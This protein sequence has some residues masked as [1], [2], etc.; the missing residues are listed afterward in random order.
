MEVI[1][2]LENLTKNYNN[3]CLALGTFDG[4][5]QGHKKLIKSAVEKAR[6]MNGTSVVMT[7][8]QHPQ[9]IFGKQKHRLNKPVLFLI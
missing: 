7:F 8:S 9:T 5:H 3:I 2:G 4:I 6:E 1:V